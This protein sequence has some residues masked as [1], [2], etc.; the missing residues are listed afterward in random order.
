MNDCE[1]ELR[2]EQSADLGNTAADRAVKRE[3]QKLFGTF[4]EEERQR[5]VDV[6]KFLEGRTAP[7]GRR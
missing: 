3:F 4:Q 6:E 2:F 7:V 1:E 5:Q